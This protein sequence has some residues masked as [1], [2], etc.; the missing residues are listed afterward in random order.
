MNQPL[1]SGADTSAS[2]T[3][4]LQ[5]T[6]YARLNPPPCRVTALPDDQ[7]FG[8]SAGAAAAWVRGPHSCR[9]SPRR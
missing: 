8:S 4:S 5:L 6:V 9:S 7:T 2:R 1:Q 3:P